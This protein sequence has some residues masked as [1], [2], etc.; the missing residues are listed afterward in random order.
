MVVMID[1]LAVTTTSGT[2]IAQKQY[3]R[4]KM[5][6]GW[7]DLLLTH[8]RKDSGVPGLLEL[9]HNVVAVSITKDE[10]IL[11]A[12][13]TRDTPPLLVLETLEKIFIV[14]SR[15]LGGEVNEETFKA[16]LVIINLLLDEVINGGIIGILEPGVLEGLIPNPQ[17]ASK[18]ATAVA[19]TAAKI[20]P[21]P[22]LSRGVNSAVTAISSA[23]SGQ[24][25]GIDQ[26]FANGD[27]WWRRG[28]IGHASNEI[29][30]DVVER[31]DAIISASGRVVTWGVL[32]VITAV[33]KLS[34]N[35]PEVTVSV[36]EGKD[37]KKGQTGGYGMV[38]GA[39][40]ASTELS[41]G[42]HTCVRKHRWIRDNVIAFTPP[43]GEFVL[44]NYHK[45]GIPGTDAPIPLNI[46]TKVGFDIEGG[47]VEMTVAPKLIALL[48]QKGQADKELEL[49]ALHLKLPRCVGSATLTTKAGT[50]RFDNEKNTLSWRVGKLSDSAPVKLEGSVKYVPEIDAEKAAGLGNEY[51]CTVSVEF[52]IKSHCVTG[53]R[54]ESLDVS[55]VNYTPYKGCRYSTRAGKIEYRV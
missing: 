44:A 46:T 6:E 24:E 2:R 53:L 42:F 5:T 19:E 43:D 18:L 35:T 20:L 34:G 29:Y 4:R 48:G 31:V 22:I 45:M 11:T 38:P 37:G 17:S 33:S 14:F 55:S 26:V 32:G 40:K 10:I 52:L 9:A 50:A 13:L 21:S 28:G 7:L 54:V 51:T 25:G 27:I 1:G 8:I 23:L 49:V 12:L 36:R 39:T 3:S 30:L 41:W 47:K 16:N 15:Y